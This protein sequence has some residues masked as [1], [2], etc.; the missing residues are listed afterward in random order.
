MARVT[1]LAL[2]LLAACAGTLVAAAT[3]DTSPVAQQVKAAFLF[4][5][6]GYVEWP[7]NAFPAADSPI[8]IGVAGDEELTQELV[9]VIAKRTLNGRPVAVQRV[10][11]DE[12]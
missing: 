12:P 9:R 4:K 3:D 10:G 8:V 7:S 6:G 1:G 5:F 11:A 2:L